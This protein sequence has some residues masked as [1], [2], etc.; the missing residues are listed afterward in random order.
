MPAVT[1]S[2]SPCKKASADQ[3]Q[4]SSSAANTSANVAPVA[5]MQAPAN[6][7]LAGVNNAFSDAMVP[8]LAPLSPSKRKRSAK[9][10][11]DDEGVSAQPSEPMKRIR[12]E[13]SDTPRSHLTSGQPDLAA[14]T[15]SQVE[16][17]VLGLE[18][19]PVFGATGG[20][21]KEGL[22]AAASTP[23][24]SPKSVETTA[25]APVLDGEGNG[26][27][28]KAPISAVSPKIGITNTC[29]C[30]ELATKLEEI[31][32]LK[33]AVAKAENDAV[34]AEEQIA[35]SQA[36]FQEKFKE[37]V[38]ET[39]AIEISEKKTRA[40]YNRIR[41]NMRDHLQS[42]HQLRLENERLSEQ[43]RIL[44]DLYEG[45]KREKEELAERNTELMEDIAQYREV[46]DL[47]NKRVPILTADQVELKQTKKL[48]AAE[49]VKNAEYEGQFQESAEFFGANKVVKSIEPVD[50]AQGG[51]FHENHNYEEY[52]QEDRS[53]RYRT[54]TPAGTQKSHRASSLVGFRESSR[55]ECLH[56]RGYNGNTCRHCGD[57]VLAE[58]HPEFDRERSVAPADDLPPSFSDEEE[59]CNRESASYEPEE[60]VINNQDEPG[61]VGSPVLTGNEDYEDND[62]EDGPQDDGASDLYD[63]EHYENENQQDHQE[64]LNPAAAVE[65]TTSAPSESHPSSSPSPSSSKKRKGSPVSAS[66]PAKKVKSTETEL[67][68]PSSPAAPRVIIDFK[69]ANS[70]WGS[71]SV[72]SPQVA[73]TAPALST[74][75]SASSFP[76]V[77]T[78]SGAA[79]QFGAATAFGAIGT[80]GPSVRFGATNSFGVP[81]LSA[82]S[83]SVAASPKEDNAEE[84]K[85]ADQNK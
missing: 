20:A 49:K 23:T 3:S 59:E 40:E 14:T 32:G 15:Y 71:P 17:V 42:T 30:D 66:S 48:L 47:M 84:D 21:P 2:K 4:A 83:S 5:N 67:A 43:N 33:A 56:D 28:A 16:R 76:T 19:T 73:V 74:P 26:A 9:T 85:P 64:S 58:G 61:K 25:T 39:N 78:R 79:V 11:S 22:D 52:A 60:A 44:S 65:K 57:H 12:V 7:A 31:T 27:M 54:P 75:S 13:R 35:R 81:A 80:A 70:G 55:W 36:Y 10:L 41:N 38:E 8:V 62:Q 63:Y 37:A 46:F 68:G 18:D 53:R 6:G 1:R 77:I 50:P 34:A 29:K 69:P 45:Q 82:K 51:M 24:S 72:L